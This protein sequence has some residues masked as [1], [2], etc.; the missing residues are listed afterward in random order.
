MVSDGDV[1]YDGP[2]KHKLRLFAIAVLLSWATP[3]TAQQPTS[4][5]EGDAQPPPS[6]QPQTTPAPSAGAPAAAP[7]AGEG[8]RGQRRFMIGA[9]P[10]LVFWPP[11]GVDAT[12]G[13]VKPAI[14][15]R[16]R[17]T[18]LAAGGI[19]GLE[20]TND[21]V[22]HDFEA[23]GD[24]YK[25]Y[26]RDPEEG[27]LNKGLKLGALWPG[28]ILVP[29]GGAN[30]TTGGGLLVY[31][32]PRAPAAFFDIGANFNLFLHLSD[33]DFKADISIGAYGGGGYEFTKVFSVSGH[34]NQF[35]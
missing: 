17:N 25:W 23:M 21:I 26:F 10:G 20:W 14:A 11:S 27:G 34:S 22:F 8:K 13:E 31:T 29:F 2:M 30:Y 5:A 35:G 4:P 3:A 28:M 16:T 6:A 15:L 18:F 7:S 19:I 33:P 24:A 32:S 9:G 12:E 1:P